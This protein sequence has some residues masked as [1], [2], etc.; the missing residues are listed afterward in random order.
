MVGHLGELATEMAKG[1]ADPDR[2]EVLGRLADLP[3]LKEALVVV[4]GPISAGKTTLV[5]ALTGVTELP[6][7]ALPTTKVP[8]VLIP[9]D[10]RRARLVDHEHRGQFE[11]TD[12]SQ[13]LR[14]ANDE[15]APTRFSR[16][17]I[18]Y[19]PTAGFPALAFVDAPGLGSSSVGEGGEGLDVL[20][21][22]D[23]VVFCWP[24]SQPP[25]RH[26]VAR[27]PAELSP[28]AAHIILLTRCDAV[29]QSEL[30]ALQEH[31]RRMFSPDAPTPVLTIGGLGSDAWTGRI[32]A[33]RTTLQS[34]ATRHSILPA[35]GRIAEL[36]EQRA[37]ESFRPMD[38]VHSATAICVRP[39]EGAEEEVW[40]A[41]RGL[42][43]DVHAIVRETA[44][45]LHADAKNWPKLSASA[46]Q[47][48]AEEATKEQVRFFRRKTRNALQ[49][50][51]E[52]L[53]ERLSAGIRLA[54][55]ITKDGLA[56]I[57]AE[58]RSSLAA[59]GLAEAAILGGAMGSGAGIALTSGLGL[60]LGE[61]FTG[62]LASILGGPLTLLAGAL[63]AGLWAASRYRAVDSSVAS[64]INSELRPRLEDAGDA[65]VAEA[66]RNWRTAVESLRVQLQ[67]SGRPKVSEAWLADLVNTRNAIA[68]LRG[69]VPGLGAARAGAAAGTLSADAIAAAGTVSA[70]V[71]AEATGGAVPVAAAAGKRRRGTR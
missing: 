43:E 45:R 33:L 69:G 55:P 71:I 11:S 4:V 32:D 13:V 35:A 42:R 27:F 30:P 21:R 19:V 18:G 20:Q 37:D 7:G 14:R 5:A 52:A 8:T 28:Q 57:T 63:G 36:L 53:M 9:A 41:V 3:A 39:L 51:H 17:E 48:A 16:A 62:S 12:I 47:D 24:A 1:E 61:L 50:Q 40:E 54:S 59:G 2:R 38:T 70:V 46:L 58:I 49:R 64:F 25:S 66:E 10:A 68:H 60:A 31:A 29:P 56:L 67:R 34:V 22:A 26:D 15:N 65:V 23:I 44:G 6:T